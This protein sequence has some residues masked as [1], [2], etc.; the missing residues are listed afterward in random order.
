MAKIRKQT[1]MWVTKDGRKIRICDMSDSHLNNTIKMFYRSFRYHLYDCQAQLYG[2]LETGPPDGACDCAEM[3]LA[4]IENLLY[5]G[6]TRDE[7]CGENLTLKEQAESS[8]PILKNMVLEQ[9]RRKELSIKERRLET[10]KRFN[11]N[12]VK[13]LKTKKDKRI[14]VSSGKSYPDGCDEIYYDEFWKE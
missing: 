5:E 2:Y 13:T 11:I 9:N 8:I 3:E 7:W 1:K 4:Q 14:F 10:R 6:Y 12:T